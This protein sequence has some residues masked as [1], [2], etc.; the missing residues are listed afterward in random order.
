MSFSQ[1]TSSSGS[2]KIPFIL[3]HLEVHYHVHKNPLFGPIQKQMNPVP[4]HTFHVTK[5]HFNIILPFTDT[6][7]T[8]SHSFRFSKQNS[9][10]RI[11]IS[12]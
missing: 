9:R 3:W 10:L 5:I 2:Q 11:Q 8:V 12:V 4:A 7:S 1:S 6:R